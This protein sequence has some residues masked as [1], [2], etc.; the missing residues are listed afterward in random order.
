MRT[1]LRLGCAARPTGRTPRTRSGSRR[2]GSSRHISTS[3]R[4]TA[5]SARSLSRRTRWQTRN[6]RRALS[7]A[8]VSYASRSP[9]CARSTNSRSI[10]L[11]LGPASR[12]HPGRSPCMRRRLTDSFKG[13]S[14]CLATAHV[15]RERCSRG[16][17]SAPAVGVGTR[18]SP[19][20]V[21][22][23]S[24]CASRRRA[25]IVVRPWSGPMATSLM[26]RCVSPRRGRSPRPSRQAPRRQPRSRRPGRGSS[27]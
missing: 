23:R 21:F 5:S 4:C 7:R 8:S 24:R 1:E 6:S 18:E 13:G 27:R 12:T 16:R 2:P 19:A 9:R 22:V 10:G 20:P 26:R 17:W 14:A 11:C 3:V 15:A 25:G